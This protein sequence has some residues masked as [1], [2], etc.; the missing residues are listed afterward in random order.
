MVSGGFEK[1]L[2]QIPF[3]A[4]EIFANLRPIPLN[5]CWRQRDRKLWLF[6]HD[7]KKPRCRVQLDAQWRFRSGVE[8]GSPQKHRE[9]VPS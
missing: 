2:L 8:N 4:L 3:A 6:I 5:P 1:I 9:I 7:L